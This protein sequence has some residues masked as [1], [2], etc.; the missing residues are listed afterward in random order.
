M[1]HNYSYLNDTQFLKQITE[2]KVLDFYTKIT[3]LNWAEEPI[4]DIQG[5][6]ITASFSFDGNSAIRRTGSMSLLIDQFINNLSNPENLISINKKIDIQI[7]F[8]NPTKQYTEYKILW[9]PLGLYVLTSVSMTHSISDLNVA[10][11]FKD[12]MCL[13]NGECGGTFPAS[14]V[15]DSYESTDE[16][17]NTVI[18]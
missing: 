8:N 17:G 1:K 13:L 12:K 11:Q 15:F 16:E 4:K 6:V 2:Q 7:G 10:I 3:I 14:V 5:K 18:V 9:F